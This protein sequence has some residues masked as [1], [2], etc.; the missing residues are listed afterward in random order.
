MWQ[1]VVRATC[2]AAGPAHARTNDQLQDEPSETSPAEAAGDLPAG[3]HGQAGNERNAD[4]ID[5]L[6]FKHH[7]TMMHLESPGP[8][9]CQDRLALQSR[10]NAWGA[11]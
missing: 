3:E 4:R 7:S 2:R 11:S 8:A 5:G 10:C 9:Q 6:D 1:Q